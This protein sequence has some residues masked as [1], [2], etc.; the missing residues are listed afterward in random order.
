MWEK[1]YRVAD[2]VVWVVDRHDH[3]RVADA[4]DALSGVLHH[5]DMQVRQVPVPLLV[6]LNKSEKGGQSGD[7]SDSDGDA[8]TQLTL[9]TLALVLQLE[10]GKMLGGE[11]EFSLGGRRVRLLESSAKE[12]WGFV[13]GMQWLASCVVA[14]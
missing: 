11:N 1:F 7:G 14:E 10:R 12:G 5:A 6:L 4:V 8:S 9:E 3:A 2:A 13:E